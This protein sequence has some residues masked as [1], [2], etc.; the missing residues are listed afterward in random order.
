[1]KTKIIRIGNSQ[2]VRI[3]KPLIEESGLT[4]EIEM[5]LRD[6]EIIIR[7]AETTRKDWEASFKKMEEQGDDSLFDKE[8]VE[9]PS[10]WD[11]TEWTW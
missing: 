8:E 3:P 11:K 4:E 6:D 2:G 10:D 7:S 1:M 5:I 9:Q